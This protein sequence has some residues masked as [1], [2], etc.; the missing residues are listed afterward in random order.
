MRKHE[1]VVFSATTLGFSAKD[2]NVTTTYESPILDLRR[3]KQFLIY[4]AL[5]VTGTVSAGTA[6]IEVVPVDDNGVDLGADIALIGAITST[7]DGQALATICGDG[8][9][10][11]ISDTLS[12]TATIAAQGAAILSCSKR[13]KLI[14][15]ATTAYNGDASSGSVTLVAK[16]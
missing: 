11:A 2:L 5:D 4:I 10:T 3:F 1:A 12:G 15:R 16:E 7:A 9:T 13:V 6:V 14:F 8:T